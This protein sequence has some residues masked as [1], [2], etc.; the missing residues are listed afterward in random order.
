MRPIATIYYGLIERLSRVT[1]SGQRIRQLDGLRFIAIATVF[2]QHVYEVVVVHYPGNRLPQ[3]DA[4]TVL[5]RDWRI[6][7][8]LFFVI[9]GFILAS[10]FAAQHLLHAKP[11]KLKQYYLRRVTRLEPPYLLNLAICYAALVLY[12]HESACGLLPHLLASALYL[13]NVVYRQFSTINPVAWSLEIEVQFY[14]LAPFLAAVFLIRS[15]RLRR[16][17]LVGVM[18]AAAQVFKVAMRVFPGLP[19]TLLDF[20]PFFLAGFLLADIYLVD[21]K[22]NPQPR[23]WADVIG[24]GGWLLLPFYFRQSEILGHVLIRPTFF[25]FLLLLLCWASFRSNYLRRFL[26][27]SFTMTVGGMCYSIYLIHLPMLRI[28]GNYF[29]VPLVTYNLSAN[30]LFYSL[31]WGSIVLAASMV[32]FMLIER[33]CMVKDWPQRL[34]ARL[35][36]QGGPS[37]VRQ[38]PSMIDVPRG[39][40]A[41]LPPNQPAP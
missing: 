28:L 31:I 32:Y 40:T 14:L 23:W 16:G 27:A 29:R 11:V 18:I 19:M 37:Q 15:R 17:V 8:E 39:S 25:P 5:V 24:I 38:S 35:R 21:W 7:V 22:Q 3:E 33:P 2:L 6:G 41:P 10:P 30:V 36:G 1:T 9:S 4:F 13:H 26:A 12:W 20:L 34:W